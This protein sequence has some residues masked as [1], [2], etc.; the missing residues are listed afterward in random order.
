MFISFQ[1]TTMYSVYNVQWKTN[2]QWQKE[3]EL[4]QIEYVFFV[5]FPWKRKQNLIFK[6]LKMSLDSN[7]ES[8]SSNNT[9]LNIVKIFNKLFKKM[10]IIKM[11]NLV[12]TSTRK[13]VILSL[14]EKL[15]QW[16]EKIS[17]NLHKITITLTLGLLYLTL[18]FNKMSFP[19]ISCFFKLLYCNNLPFISTTDPF[20]WP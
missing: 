10:N 20:I 5:Y 11:Q 14:W 8:K 9:Y 17:I 6:R 15:S 7:I 13:R 18:T 1:C 19:H 4:F 12:V 3:C 16:M 2:I